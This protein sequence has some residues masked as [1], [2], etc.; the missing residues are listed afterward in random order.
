MPRALF[1]IALACTALLALPVQAQVFATPGQVVANTHGIDATHNALLD[2][3]DATMRVDPAAR[4]AESIA[5]LLQIA[6]DAE[7][8]RAGLGGN[9]AQEV[10][11]IDLIGSV[12]ALAAFRLG[13]DGYDE[14]TFEQLLEYRQRALANLRISV[15]ES[16]EDQRPI[17]DYRDIAERL[18]E[19]AHYAQLPQAEEWS[20][21]WLAAERLVAEA[22]RELRDAPAMNLA[23]ALNAHGWLTSDAALLAEAEAI[24]TSAPDQMGWRL[25]MQL[26]AMAAGIAPYNAPGEQF[27]FYR[28]QP[29]D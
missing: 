19:M 1:L 7:V 9:R 29:G 4:D 26:D 15:R 27:F 24:Y 5:Q 28:A 3:L 16:P 2:R 12:Y 14:E 10:V 22:M 18:T 23:R 17:M 21:E 25:Q 20:A 13:R 8:W 6:A 11:A